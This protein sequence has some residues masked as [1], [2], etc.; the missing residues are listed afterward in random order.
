VLINDQHGHVLPGELIDHDYVAS[1]VGPTDDDTPLTFQ[2]A[3][4]RVIPEYV[5]NF[6]SAAQPIQDFLEPGAI[7]SALLNFGDPLGYR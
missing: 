7:A 3:G 2:L 1:V 6:A 5:G 4:E